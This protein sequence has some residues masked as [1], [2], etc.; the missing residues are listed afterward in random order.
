MCCPK[1]QKIPYCV[2]VVCTRNENSK[3]AENVGRYAINSKTYEED[4]VNWNSPINLYFEYKIDN[5]QS[6]LK[7]P[8]ILQRR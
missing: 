3:Y 8:H 4:S 5:W 6:N 1:R 7:V 2:R